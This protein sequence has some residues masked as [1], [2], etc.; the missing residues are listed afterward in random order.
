MKRTCQLNA[1]DYGLQFPH[2]NAG[3]PQL[4]TLARGTSINELTICL[5]NNGVRDGWFRALRN[6]NPRYDPHDP[7]AAGSVL[8]VPPY[9]MR[10]YRPNCWLPQTKPS[11]F[12]ADE[13]AFA[14]K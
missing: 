12:P 3:E 2:I 1:K 14:K 7:I 6:L 8:R 9:V 5:G 11:I 10:L 13:I 4:L